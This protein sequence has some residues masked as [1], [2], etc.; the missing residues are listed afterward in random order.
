MPLEEAVVS[1]ISQKWARFR[2]PP[3]S[4]LQSSVGLGWRA[5]RADAVTR[6]ERGTVR[7][8]ITSLDLPAGRRLVSN[9]RPE[10]TCG[11]ALR[12]A[13][14]NWLRGKAFEHWF[15]NMNS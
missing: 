3:R 2:S 1:R 11:S 6:S 5:V 7:F 10:R 15:D 12:L 13:L 14:R 9:L 8:F 4:L